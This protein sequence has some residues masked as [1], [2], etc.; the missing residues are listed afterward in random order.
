[1][2]GQTAS[3]LAWIETGHQTPSSGVAPHCHTLA[4]KKTNS[5]TE[6]YPSWSGKKY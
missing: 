3:T 5:F 2:V 4:A 6:E 1:M